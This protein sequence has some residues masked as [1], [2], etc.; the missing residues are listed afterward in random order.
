VPL[1]GSPRLWR[2]GLRWDYGRRHST[3]WGASCDCFRRATIR[4]E[5]C[6]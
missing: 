6:A 5:G 4:L 3:P 1:T 2:A